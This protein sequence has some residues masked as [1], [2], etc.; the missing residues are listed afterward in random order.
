[1]C[2]MAGGI[3]PFLLLLRMGRF[4]LVLGHIMGRIYAPGV[5]RSIKFPSGISGSVLLGRFDNLVP[6]AG[7]AFI[8]YIAWM[9][10]FIECGSIPNSFTGCGPMR[11]SEAYRY[12]A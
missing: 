5:G 8:Y 4:C 3:W 6:S 11:S 1:L 2:S 9:N 10:V 12:Y 7:I